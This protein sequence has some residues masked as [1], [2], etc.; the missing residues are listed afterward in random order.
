MHP[1]R[2]LTAIL[3]AAWAQDA[4]GRDI[5][6][7]FGQ[8]IQ[9]AVDLA[10]PG[11]RILVQPGTYREPG[12]YCPTDP[13]KVCAVVVAKDNISLLAESGPGQPVILENFGGQSQGIAFGRSHVTPT[14]CL[15]NQTKSI[16][17]GAVSGFVVRNFDD[18]GIFLFCVDGF[19]ISANS[20]V[21]NKIYGIFPVLSGNGSINSNVASGAHDT[22]IYIGQSHDV[23]VYGN[24]AH[25]N[26]S[27]FEI[28]NSLNVELDHNESFSNTAGILMFVLPG[29]VVL[30]SQN[31]N[32][33][34]NFVH[35]NNSP[36]TCV[37]PGDDV[38]LVPPGLGI[39]S[40]AGD[41]NLIANNRVIR[42]RTIGILLTDTCTALQIPI[43]SCNLGFDPLPEATRIEFNFAQGNGFNSAPSLPGADLLWT[44]N[45]TGNCWLRNVAKVVIPPNLPLC[46]EPAAL[47]Q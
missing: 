47:K 35:D 33:H 26:V 36:N 28:E 6:V 22:G 46:T 8:S 15:K 25:D 1:M 29:D 19:S 9:A 20:T 2:L 12:R 42:N 5:T 10:S 24:T 17:G 37:V 32:V 31:N 27:G 3:I 43:S 38:C 34:D 13:T 30:V 44:G 41:H 23:H 18:T 7:Q 11:D 14:Q 39:S 21:D 4:A 16:S 45:G 40:A